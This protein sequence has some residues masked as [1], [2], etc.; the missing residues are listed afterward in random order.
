LRTSRP[1]LLRGIV[2]ESPVLDWGRVLE[3]QA[4]ATRIPVPL[5]LA[6]I[7]AIA[8]SWGRALTGLDAAVDFPG[9]DVVSRADE[10]HLPMLVLHSDDDGFV[11]SSGSHDLAAVRPDIV[12]FERFTVARHT[13]LWNY[14]EKRWT[15]AIRDWA[16]TLD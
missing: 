13:K 5:R 10:L 8:N 1:D 7:G 4:D 6:A 14:D 3:F 16:A 12:T 11:P 9:L 2:L 15:S